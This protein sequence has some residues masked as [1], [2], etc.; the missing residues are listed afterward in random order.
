MVLS[1]LS[2]A[3]PV[4]HGYGTAQWQIGFSGN[5][6]NAAVCGPAP[7]GVMFAPGTSG[8]WGWCEFSGS[9]ASGLT[10][11]SGDCQVTSYARTSLGQPNNP[12][13]EA[14]SVNGWAIETPSGQP[15]PS[16]FIT[17]GTAACTGPGAAMGCFPAV[18]NTFIPAIPGHF[19]MS[20]SP[21]INFELQVTHITA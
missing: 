1:I 7:P 9:S 4:A 2:S 19:S 5:C 8:F 18:G 6:D 12:S 17:A 15:F 14:I 10:G 3:F 16:F 21:A 20:P 11:T 13:N